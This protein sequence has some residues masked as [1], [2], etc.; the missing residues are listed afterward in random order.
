MT[1]YTGTGAHLTTEQLRV[2][3]SLL[4]T[5]R[6]LETE[7]ETELIANHA[8]THREYEVLVRVDGGGGSARM[9]ALAR[10]IEA[11]APLVTQT[12]KRLEERGWIIRQPAPSD[13]RGVD[14]VLT[15]R[16]RRALKDAAPPHAATIRRLLLDPIGPNLGNIAEIAG[17]LAD[18]LRQHRSA[19][20][21][22]DP[23]CS[24]PSEN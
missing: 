20:S 4:D 18:H 3:T 21:C 9:S 19:G 7:L 11:S 24:L 1:N 22:D 15:A 14:A 16:G 5:I 2:W 23:A 10:Q 6:I 13:K 8:M 12:V 17:P